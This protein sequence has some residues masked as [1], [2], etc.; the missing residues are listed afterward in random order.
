[1]LLP[2]EYLDATRSYPCMLPHVAPRVS[3]FVGDG[4]AVTLRRRR[5][6]LHLAAL[7]YFL[8]NQTR[9]GPASSR[10]STV[11]KVDAIKAARG[12]RRCVTSTSD[13]SVSRWSGAPRTRFATT[14]P[15]LYL[16]FMERR[17]ADDQVV[18]LMFQRIEPV[19]RNQASPGDVFTGGC[20]GHRIDIEKVHTGRG[21]HRR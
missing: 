5:L 19:R 16:S 4:P 12:R 11:L 13:P 2:H 10:T 14:L 7:G 15:G 18:A 21:L 3:H 6:C 1:M 20:E 17:V 8:P 9:W